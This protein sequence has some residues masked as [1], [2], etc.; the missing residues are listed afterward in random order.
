MAE[1]M[2]AD[3]AAKDVVSEAIFPPSDA[4]LSLA[5]F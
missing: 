1:G 3:V 4:S 5:R 2:K